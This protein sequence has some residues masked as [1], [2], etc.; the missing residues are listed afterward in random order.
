[1]ACF[2]V[3]GIEYP[4]RAAAA[5]AHGL[6]PSC[7]RTRLSRGASIEE[8]FA[9]NKQ[10]NTL[11][12]RAVVANIKA[13]YRFAGT[14]LVADGLPYSKAT[15][16]GRSRQRFIRVRC[17]CRPEKVIERRLS[18]IL[19]GSAA[20]CGCGNREALRAAHRKKHQAQ[21]AVEGSSDAEYTGTVIYKGQVS[22]RWEALEDGQPIRS[23]SGRRRY[24]VR[25]VC[26]RCGTERQMPG[27]D[28][29]NRGD[30]CR[31]CRVTRQRRA[32]DDKAARAADLLNR[33]TT[34]EIP[35]PQEPIAA[36]TLAGTAHHFLRILTE[37]RAVG[38]SHHHVICQ[39]TCGRFLDLPYSPKTGLGKR[40]SCGCKRTGTVSH[41]AALRDQTQHML[42]I[43]WQYTGP[44]NHQP[45]LMRSSWELAVAHRLDAI[46]AQW[47]YEPRTFTL[48]NGFAYVPD[49]YVPAWDAWIEV[50]GWL[51]S[52]SRNKIE[53]L[54]NSGIRLILLGK[55][56]CRTFTG[57]KEPSV[58]Y[59][60]SA[61]RAAGVRSTNNYT[62]S[63]RLSERDATAILWF[64]DKHPPT[65]SRSSPHSGSIKFLA[66]W[67][68]V[69]ERTITDL[70]KGR[71]FPTLDRDKR[72]RP[73][74]P[75][76]RP[77]K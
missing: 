51:R 65:S 3:G 39:C 53:T 12:N 35:I 60:S 68:K 47:L 55:H 77:R 5:K 1:M 32:Q 21:L 63:S 9:P 49:F 71:T 18:H 19:D 14:R 31:T 43:R 17:D 73:R 24:F 59:A 74:P 72:P 37:P 48:P 34:G 33:F 62:S 64:L 20:S 42:K 23:N 36:N 66:R 2:T 6:S 7:V 54:R 30:S 70:N 75:T 61:I 57:I 27:F 50:K 45:I 46:N 58:H 41:K 76:Y 28:F 13:G 44:S 15:R 4:S 69:C 10:P 38:K 56:S 26:L 22:G 67:F 8:A 11:R 40:Q 25:A 52:A 29:R 16:S